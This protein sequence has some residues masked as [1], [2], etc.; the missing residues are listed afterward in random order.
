MTCVDFDQAL[1]HQTCANTACA[2]ALGIQKIGEQQ[3]LRH[4]KQASKG[5]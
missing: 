5:S 3:A 4:V 1:L 2:K